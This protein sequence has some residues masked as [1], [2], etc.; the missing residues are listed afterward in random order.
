VLRRPG[1]KAVSGG[2]EL[3]R[4]ENLKIGIAVVGLAIS[5]F[6]CFFTYQ[7]WRAERAAIGLDLYASLPLGA[8][9]Q[10]AM[11]RATYDLRLPRDARMWELEADRL[12]KISLEE[13][14]T[15]ARV[16]LRRARLLA[17]M[18]SSIRMRETYLALRKP[19][20][21]TSFNQHFL[22]W[23]RLSPHD[24]TM[25]DWRLAIAAS[26]WTRLEPEARDRAL[27]DAEDLCL[28]WGKQRTIQFV[29]SSGSEAG[30]ATALRL[31]RVK[32]KCVGG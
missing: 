3:S 12:L 24:T 13:N 9:A 11:S 19:E 15:S 20:S 21:G 2:S 28:R 25:Q 27:N 5:A 30:L 31:E 26:G 17:P 8:T 32:Q 7:S 29:N 6:G 1:F 4:A 14:A 16:A 22:E 23:H 18:R 10:A